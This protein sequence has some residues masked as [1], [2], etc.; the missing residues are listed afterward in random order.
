MAG[1]VSYCDELTANEV[2]LSQCGYCLSLRPLQH[3]E[4]FFNS[5]MCYLNKLLKYYCSNLMFTFLVLK[6]CG[7]RFL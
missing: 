5:F 2:L 3:Q 1:A 4:D 6:M 7:V